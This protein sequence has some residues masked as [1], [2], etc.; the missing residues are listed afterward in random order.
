[1]WLCLLHLLFVGL[2]CP[3]LSIHPPAPAASRPACSG[4]L[5]ARLLL[6]TG[7]LHLG[8]LRSGHERGVSGETALGSKRHTRE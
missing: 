3:H 6:L 8:W 5:A 4:C 7:P 1:V 2:H